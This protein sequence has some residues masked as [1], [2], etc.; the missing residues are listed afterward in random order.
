MVERLA[1]TMQIQCKLIK[2]LGLL[3]ASAAAENVQQPVPSW[4]DPQ[5]SVSASS[6]SAALRKTTHGEW[7]I[8]Y[9]LPDF[10]PVV[11]DSLARK[12]K[13]LISK[14]RSACKNALITCVFDQMT[15]YTW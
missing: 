10:P 1:P 4:E 14:E 2:A 3:K 13:R 11:S 7:P 9:K 8:I 6:E 5:P 12:D 15:K